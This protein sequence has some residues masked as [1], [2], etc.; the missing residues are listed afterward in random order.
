LPR[1]WALNDSA[2]VH[3][4]IVGFANCTSAIRCGVDVDNNVLID[5][6]DLTGLNLLYG[7]AEAF[8]K[9]S[10]KLVR[11]LIYAAMKRARAPHSIEE[12]GSLINPQN[13]E[14]LIESIVKAMHASL[15]P[16][17]PESDDSA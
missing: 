13:M 1:Q 15:P 5:V 3:R 8:Q 4:V 9:P 6:E 10:L 14:M 2:V 17:E 12:I 7:A 16:P 11:A